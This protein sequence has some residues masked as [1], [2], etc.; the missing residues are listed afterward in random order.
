MV[1]YLLAIKVVV[2]TNGGPGTSER[3]HW[4]WHRDGNIDA[5][6]GCEVWIRGWNVQESA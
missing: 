6:L 4:Q 1:T 3:E 2:T 5:H